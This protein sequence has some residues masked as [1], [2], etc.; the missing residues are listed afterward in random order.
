M[1]N[2]TFWYII[3]R[4][5]EH[6]LRKLFKQMQDFPLMFQEMTAYMKR[7]MP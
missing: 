5:Q 6:T 1:G 3:P 2:E 7:S 4:V